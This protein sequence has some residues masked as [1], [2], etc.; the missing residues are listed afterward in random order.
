M[1]LVYILVFLLLVMVKAVLL[2]LQ[3]A[4]G[5]DSGGSVIPGQ[6]QKVQVT[7][8]GVGYTTASIDIEA[9]DGIL[10]GNTGSGADLNVVIPPFGTGASVFT[11]VLAL[12][13]LRD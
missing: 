10:V 13:R 8:F 12:V 6:I 9:I 7:S 4:D 11:K 2:K 3:V 1:Q 5:S